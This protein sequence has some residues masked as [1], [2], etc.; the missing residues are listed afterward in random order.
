[1]KQTNAASVNSTKL[2]LSINR[3]LIDIKLKIPIERAA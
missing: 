2:I 3:K 1:L